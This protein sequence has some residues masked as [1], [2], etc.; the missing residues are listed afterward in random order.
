MFPGRCWFHIQDPQK[1]IRRMFM[2]VR[3][4]CLE[5][6]Q[7]P[8]CKILKLTSSNISKL[9]VPKFQ[10][11]KFSSFKIAGTHNCNL[12]KALDPHTCKKICFRKCHGV[13]SCIICCISAANI[14]S[15][16]QLFGSCWEYPEM[17][18]MILETIPKH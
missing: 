7:I 5:N 17:S 15:Q 16:V 6:P 1:V 14:E 12:F 10:T 8:N 11:I 9:Q 13:F 4:Q 18:K 2:I 3:C